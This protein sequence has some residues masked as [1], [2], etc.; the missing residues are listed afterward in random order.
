M[1]QFKPMV[2]METTEPS[3]ELKLKKGGCVTSAK[4]MMNGGVMGALAS[5]PAPG[6]RGGMAPAAR[7]GKPS[8]MDRR[9]AMMGR[10]AMAR[11]MMAKGGAMDALEAHAA[12]PA[13]KGH[14][15]LKTGGVA[16]SPKPGNY[17]TGGVVNGQGGFKAGGIIKSEKGSTKMSTAKV[18]HNSAP[19][20]EVKLGN[21]GGFKKG[22]ATKKHYA[23]GGAVNN[24]GHAV[25]MPE[26]QA[27]KPVSNDRQS[28]TF[29]K[30]GSVTPAQK[31]EQSA[32]KAENATA[33]K[34]AKAYSNEKYG[35]KMNEGGS[36]SDKEQKMLDKAYADSIGPSKEDM[37]MAKQIRSIPRKM[38]EGAKSLFTTKEK[39]A[40]SVTKTEKSVTVA[41]ARKRGGSVTC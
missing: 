11:P 39:P 35:R 16:K 15:G 38:Y 40:G 22:G 14:A 12:K 20:G 28:G 33:M 21:A 34:Q 41:P 27:S 7:P 9:K 6:A 8:M 1:G 29:K 2:K 26:K 17:A 13:S 19:T 31:K 4:K 25:A 32:F 10:S 37:D 5:A 18:N 24:S 30:G 36:T 3:V 23:T